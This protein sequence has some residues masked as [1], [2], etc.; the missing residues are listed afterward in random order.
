MK[1]NR[2]PFK[3]I[4][5]NFIV[6]CLAAGCTADVGGVAQPAVLAETPTV[7]HVFAGVGE[8]VDQPESIPLPAGTPTKAPLFEPATMPTPFSVTESVEITQLPTPTARP[9][10]ATRIVTIYDEALNENWTL[11]NSFDVEYELS[12]GLA[13]YN[14]RFSLAFTPQA[15]YG[16]LMFTV[17]PGSE[18]EYLRQDVLAVQFWLYS[19]DDYVE[20]DDFLVSIVGSNE[21]SYWVEGDDSV[22]VNDSR[23]TFPS[24]RLYFLNVEEDIPPDTWIQIEVWL[25]DLIY[26]P[27]YQYVTGIIIKNDEDFLRTAYVDEVS[28]IMIEDR[29]N[30]VPVTATSILTVSMTPT[31]T[32]T[33]QVE[34]ATT[35]TAKATVDPETTPAASATLVPEPETCVVSPSPGWELYQIQSG[36]IISNLAFERGESTESVFS[37]NC[38]EPGIVLSVGQEIWLPPLL[39]EDTTPEPT[40]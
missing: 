23:P 14:G 5:L 1:K 18:E 27:D 11:E 40:P 36:D 19:G 16:N 13:S 35:P 12:E 31:P 8:T 22:V 9:T 34:P 38:L 17:A 10:I 33:L 6:V 4:V 32:A 28:L 30:T 21:Y 25:N 37:V 24:T 20:T 15:G 2:L 26:D 29:G 39:P 3:L 7:H